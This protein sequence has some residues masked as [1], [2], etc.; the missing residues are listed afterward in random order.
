MDKPFHF[1]MGVKIVEKGIGK[2]WQTVRL[3]P[4]LAPFLKNGEETWKNDGE[5]P[6]FCYICMI[7]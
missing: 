3:L 5:F 4:P 1:T 6:R 2:R 7:H